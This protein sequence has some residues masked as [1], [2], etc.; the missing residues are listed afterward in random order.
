[1]KRAGTA[2]VVAGLAVV[3]LVGCGSGETSSKGATT[4]AK[5]VLWNP[6][7]EIPDDALR[8]AGVDPA[9][10][11]KGVAGVPQ[12]GWEI[13]GW[14]GPQY[15]LTV[16]TTNKSVAQF[17]EKPGNVDFRDVAIAGRSGREFRV[18]GASKQLDCNVVF[19][20]S[21]GVVQ[22]QVLGSAL[23]DNLGDPC[24]HLANA[25]EVLVPTFPK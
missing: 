23:I 22:L 3:G 20:A 16:Y 7:T 18:A 19:P 24:Q 2:V 4:T 25:G 10:E 8:A 15:S 21:Q 1:M 5:P 12:S 6:C 9:T 13:C 14:S 17:E 11:E